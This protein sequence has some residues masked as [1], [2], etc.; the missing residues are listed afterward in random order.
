[1][2]PVPALH[3]QCLGTQLLKRRRAV[4]LCRHTGLL[5]KQALRRDHLLED[6]SG[7]FVLANMIDGFV[8]PISIVNVDNAVVRGNFDANGNPLP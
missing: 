1:M 3:R 5:R 8:T 4:D 2:K 7:A 6:G